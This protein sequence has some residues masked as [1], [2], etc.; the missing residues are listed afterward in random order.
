MATAT[1]EKKKKKICKNIKTYKGI[2]FFE[3]CGKPLVISKRNFK[4]NKLSKDGFNHT[5]IKC[6]VKYEKLKEELLKETVQKEEDKAKAKEEKKTLKRRA[7]EAAQRVMEKKKA[8]EKAL[9]EAE[10]VERIAQEEKEFKKAKEDAEKAT[11]E[12]EEAKAN[13][14]EVAKALEEDQSERDV[15]AEALKRPEVLFSQVKQARSFGSKS[16]ETIEKLTGLAKIEENVIVFLHS[17]M[18]F[19]D[20]DD[21]LFA[22]KEDVQKDMCGRFRVE[23]SATLKPFT[24]K[25]SR[26]GWVECRKEQTGYDTKKDLPI[27]LTTHFNITAAG[28]EWYNLWIEEQGLPKPIVPKKLRIPKAHETHVKT[29]DGHSGSSAPG[30]L[31]TQFE[32]ALN[33]GQNDVNAKDMYIDFL[34]DY[35][36]EHKCTND[37]LG[38]KIGVS[39][40]VISLAFGQKRYLSPSHYPAVA[41]LMN[42]NKTKPVGFSEPSSGSTEAEANQTEMSNQTALPSQYMATDKHRELQPNILVNAIAQAT[43]E[44]AVAILNVSEAELK[45]RIIANKLKFLESEYLNSN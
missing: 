13:E 32:L 28:I 2:P 4:E 24:W 11:H 43:K 30:Q 10:E 45:V 19:A 14:A 23:G 9:Q 38:R 44:H 37:S 21:G 27:Q 34:I 33:E 41:S 26:E 16:E 3:G 8:E 1:M 7:K 15:L 6:I 25:A 29:I 31:N 36:E 35:K 39:G 5:C 40:P 17:I 12:A 42:I 20:P 22:T 18:L